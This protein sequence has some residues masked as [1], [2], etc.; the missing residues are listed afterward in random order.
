M[1]V[2][3]VEVWME[4]TRTLFLLIIMIIITV[5]KIAIVIII[6]LQHTHT[7]PSSHSIHTIWRGWKQ[8]YTLALLKSFQA[9]VLQN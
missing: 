6:L 5:I 9:I 4:S 3:N 8:T 7:T 2:N 1:E